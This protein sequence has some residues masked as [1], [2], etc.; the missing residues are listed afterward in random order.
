MFFS[1]LAGIFGKKTIE[2]KRMC[3]YYAYDLP[4]IDVHLGHLAEVVSIRFPYCSITLSVLCTGKEVTVCS[5][6][7]G[8]GI[9]YGSPF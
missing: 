4:L 2:V 1:W 8:I 6:F 5:P 7:M 3:T 9:S